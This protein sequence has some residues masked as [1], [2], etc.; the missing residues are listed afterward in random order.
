MG[1]RKLRNLCNLG[2]YSSYKKLAS[3]KKPKCQVWENNGGNSRNSRCQVQTYEMLEG[4][5]ASAYVLH[6]FQTLVPR[7]W[8]EK[9]RV[10]E[11]GGSERGSELFSE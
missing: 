5:S 3:Y 7:F 11:I 2:L 10:S 9:D 6:P 1:K 8:N 4:T